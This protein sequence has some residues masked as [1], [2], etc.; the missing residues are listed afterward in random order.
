METKNTIRKASF[1]ELLS[2]K[3]D[4]FSQALKEVVSPSFKGLIQPE[5][6]EQL[7]EK[8]VRL[9]RKSFP[10]QARLV[11][12][13]VTHLRKSRYLIAS[14][15][16]GTGKT[17]MGIATAY[18]LAN[19][20]GFKTLIMCPT[21]LVQKWASEV[22]AVIGNTAS[23][24]IVI[25]R[26]W[27]DLV[28][29][30]NAPLDPKKMYF[31]IL[32]KET[33]KLG[34]PKTDV[35]IKKNIHV[36]KDFTENVKVCPNCF[37][38]LKGDLRCENEFTKLDKETGD[39]VSIGVCGSSYRQ[40][41]ASR[42]GNIKQAMQYFTDLTHGNKAVAPKNDEKTINRRLSVAEYIKRQ[43]PKGFFDLAIFDEMHEL[44]GGDT[45][46][47]N[48]FGAI[49]S[50]SKKI[51]GLTGTLLNGYASS[52]FYI[53]YRLDPRLMKQTLRLNYGDVE[54][55]VRMFGAV[56]ETYESKDTKYEG[57][58]TKKGRKTSV[59]ELP[60][61][62]PHLMTLLLPTTIFLRLDEMNIALPDYTESVELIEAD[63]EWKEDYLEYIKEIAIACK[64]DRRLAGKLA[65]DA[66]SVAD[67][68]YNYHSANYD[69]DGVDASIVYEPQ[70]SRND[71]S[72]TSKERRALEI[73]QHELSQDRKVLMFVTY[74]G[75]GTSAALEKVLGDNLSDKKVQMLPA[76]IEPA[77][78]ERWINDH[79]CDV[80]ICNPELVKTGLDL[81]QFPT[82]IF[83]QTTYNVFTLK[84][85]AR[86]SWRIGQDKE[87]K[88]FFLV[89]AG[90]PQQKALELIS[91]KVAAANSLEG[92]FSESE[93]LAALAEDSS[94]LQVAM[95]KA[96][97][98]GENGRAEDIQLSS[99]TNY[100]TRE[101]DAFEK[102]YIEIDQ[103]SQA[104]HAA[105]KEIEQNKADEIRQIEIQA[106]ATSIVEEIKPI[107]S[108]PITIAKIKED[109]YDNGK[110][111]IYRRIR[112]GK[113]WIEQKL[114]VTRDEIRAMVAD[115]EAIIQMSL[116]DF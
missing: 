53:L 58:Y 2:S 100:G 93:D 105:K 63:E 65:N 47:G 50:M 77:K 107:Q 115:G 87:V 46:Q 16:M 42:R 97:L 92:R 108:H 101:W 72:M 112:Q 3:R 81:L 106:V 91:K 21:H 113:K 71:F 41:E 96:I 57:V 49:A 38:P 44:K 83:F 75:L 66:I 56:E 95:A 54:R 55:F 51:M 34:F 88:V 52:L 104:A 90:T 6:Y 37:Q 59:K 74:T 79:P 15:E 62:S 18:A 98:S 48:A 67:L 14:A 99:V 69:N 7:M 26:K 73:C 84:Q 111:P 43:M 68:P 12:A 5:S 27:T 36:Y 17:Q 10:R 85:A 40:P 1:E 24:E 20:S 102:H 60:K 116:F 39:Y 25:V 76:S 32:S 8:L 78:R 86:R 28:G 31:F 33:A 45:G 64:A 23:Y 94:N 35:W 29:Y 82:I 89:Y 4:A 80:L 61:I 11:S 9:N 13:A 70:I 114:E 22:K 109:E 30:N 19:G 110:I 103:Q